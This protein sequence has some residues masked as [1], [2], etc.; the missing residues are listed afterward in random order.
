MHDIKYQLYRIGI[1]SCDYE[2]AN[3]VESFS[4]TLLKNFPDRIKKEMVENF[5][6]MADSLEFGVLSKGDK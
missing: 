2:R 4:M 1:D 3:V 5:R 6:A